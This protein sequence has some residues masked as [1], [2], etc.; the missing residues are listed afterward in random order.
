MS[1]NILTKAL[2]VLVVITLSAVLLTGCT[3]FSKTVTVKLSGNDTA[4]AQ[5]YSISVDDGESEGFLTGTETLDITG[6]SIGNHTFKATVSGYSG[7]KKAFISGLWSITAT[8]P[9]AAD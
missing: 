2:L 9:V 1:K 4:L 6:L 5:N 7:E 3:F 8:I